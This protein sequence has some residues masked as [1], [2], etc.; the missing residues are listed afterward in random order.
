MEDKNVTL[1]SDQVNETNP[2]LAGSTMTKAGRLAME[3]SHEKK[4]LKQELEE[5]QTEYDEI[6]PT[7]PTGTTDWYV[8][9]ISML[10]AVAGIFLLS[11]NLI[12]YGQVAYIISSVGWIYVGMQWGDRAIMI[13]SAVSCTAIA[14]N[15]VNTLT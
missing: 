7:T 2:S 6:K 3:L 10:L 13:G 4:R 14:M 8:K 5:L 15:L 11:A 1:I 9:W 12:F